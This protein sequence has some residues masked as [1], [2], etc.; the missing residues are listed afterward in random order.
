M[1]KT[2]EQAALQDG[3]RRLFGSDELIR[4]VRHRIAVADADDFSGAGEFKADEVVRRG[5]RPALRVGDLHGDDGGILA[6]RFDRRAM[7][8]KLNH[9]ELAGGFNFG[10]ED[11]LSV[12]E[13]TRQQR[14]GRVF[15][16]PFEVRVLGPLN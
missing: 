15:H 2:I 7:R 10:G 8:Q 9:G 14:A 13:A 6:V 12:L 11:F 3:R 1:G 16:R 5:N 4:L